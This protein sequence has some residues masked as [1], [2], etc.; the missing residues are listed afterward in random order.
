MALG[1]RLTKRAAAFERATG[2]DVA[3]GGP[4]GQLADYTSETNARLKWVV[5]ALAVA[6]ALVLMIALRAVLLPLVAVAFNLLTAAATFGI[7]Q[8]LFGGSSPPLGG[9]G[10]ID[11]MSIIGIFSVI[12]G[13]TLVYE[14]ILLARTRERFMQTGSPKAALA[15][16]LRRTAA[17][18]TGAGAVMLAAVVPFAAADMTAVRQFGVGIAVAVVLDVLIVRPVLLPAAVGVLG[19][20]A[21]WPSSPRPAGPSPR[22]PRGEPAAPAAA[23]ADTRALV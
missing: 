5:V 17:V 7:L 3:V 13:L 12:F 4:A 22:P 19:R 21:W 2:T 1:E 8:L 14:T 20:R 11:P 16:G 15:Q 18:A 9:P 10:Y 6:V 23:T